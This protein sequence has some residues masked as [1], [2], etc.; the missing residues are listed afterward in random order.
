MT[1]VE[2]LEKHGVSRKALLQALCRV[3]G[4]QV[5][6]DGLFNADPHPGN[7]CKSHSRVVLFCWFS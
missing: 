3:M 7:I 5:F 2:E 1:D 6:V 4:H